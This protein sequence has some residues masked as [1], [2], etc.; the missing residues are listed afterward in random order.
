LE[1]FMSQH[2]DERVTVEETGKML[3]RIM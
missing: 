1:S 2:S 3:A